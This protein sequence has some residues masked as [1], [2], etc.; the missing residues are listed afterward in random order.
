MMGGENMETNEHRPRLAFDLNGD[1]YFKLRK[2]LEHGEGKILFGVIVD[3]LLKAHDKHGKIAIYAI[4][5]KQVDFMKFM[6]KHMEE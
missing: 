2:I 4:M 3:A 5:S 6:L 1:Q